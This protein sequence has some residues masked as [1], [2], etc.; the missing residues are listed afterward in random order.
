MTT[1]I[2][3]IA[4]VTNVGAL[5][6]ADL[7]ARVAGAPLDTATLSALGLFLTSDVTTIA[8][9]VISRTITVAS[10]P[11][12]AQTI[13]P[14]LAPGDPT[15]SPIETVSVD[16]INVA[17]N[18]PRPPILLAVQPAGAPAPVVP[19][20]LLAQLGVGAVTF[21]GG[22]GYGAGTTA[23]VSGGGLAY[24]GAQATLGVT[25][26]GGSITAVSVITPGGPY[27]TIPTV[28]LGNTGGGTGGSITVSLEVSAVQVV[29]GGE[30]YV[31]G[32]TISQ[33]PY[34]KGLCP[35]SAGAV[36]QASLLFGFMDVIIEKAT[37]SPVI[38][39]CVA[40]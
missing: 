4:E 18:Y 33:T 12:V 40:S 32:T 30:G 29:E 13:T 37:R 14:H 36:E 17:A 35:D 5:S 10:V 6:N 27:N 2:Q 1:Q 16:T 31:A 24:G 22:T 39:T 26:M 8:G 23:T 21:V 3:Y 25:V 19:A 38:S 11:A 15:G 34:F 9:Q 7:E 20:K 28:T